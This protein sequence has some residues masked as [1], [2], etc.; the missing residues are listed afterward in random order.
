MRQVLRHIFAKKQA[1]ARLPL[2]E[3]MRDEQLDPLERLAFYP[4]M[5]YFILSFGDLN[6]FVLRDERD[7]DMYQDMVNGH[8]REDD[9][10]W[11]WYL[12]DLTKLGFD[13]EGRGTDWMGFLWGEET[14]QNRILTAR[15]TE[16]IKG[17][18]G[19]ERLV[20]IEAIEETGNVLFGAMLPIAQA[21]EERL[22]T[23][24][25]YCGPFHFERESGHAVNADHTEL[26]RISLDEE[27]RARY[28]AL[29]DQVFALFE[30]WTHEL[31]RYA[32]AH[33][34]GAPM[35]ERDTDGVSQV[36]TRSAVSRVIAA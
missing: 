28:K 13:V 27:T 10:H 1:Y 30:P 3:R 20:I 16:L 12:E 26:A 18:S 31:L 29:A 22:G 2:F 5:A 17:T 8:T 6:R 25:R 23:Q 7:P 14:L 35:D 15:L 24:L 19:L 33:P 34:V 4:C 36:M 32:V 11:P 9:H 21:L